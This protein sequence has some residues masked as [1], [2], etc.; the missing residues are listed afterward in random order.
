MP[1]L[2]I[3]L[4]KIDEKGPN[5]YGK[6]GATIGKTFNSFWNSTFEISLTPGRHTL[7]V[8]SIS[9]S[10][11]PWTGEEIVTSF[12]AMPSHIYVIEAV[13]DRTWQIWKPLIIDVT[14]SLHP[15]IVPIETQ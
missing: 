11:P 12:E 5:E 10:E 4:F 2:E 3:R 6:N 15:S 9:T 7:R 13:H 8:G 14:D 1:G